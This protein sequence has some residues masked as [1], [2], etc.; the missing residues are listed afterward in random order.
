MRFLTTGSNKDI[1]KSERA[2]RIWSKKGSMSRV[3]CGN[4]RTVI[5]RSM[6]M[7]WRGKRGEVTGV[8]GHV[9]GCSSVHIV[10]GGSLESHAVEVVGEG[11]RVQG[12][13]QGRSV[14]GV[15]GVGVHRRGRWRG[16]RHVALGHGAG[17]HRS[18][19]KH[20]SWVVVKGRDQARTHHRVHV[21]G[22]RPWV[23]WAGEDRHDGRRDTC[24]PPLVVAR[25]GT[26]PIAGVGVGVR[27]RRGRGTALRTA[28]RCGG[29]EGSGHGGVVVQGLHLL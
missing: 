23:L 1:T 2:R 24:L 19:T 25:A 6:S 15:V 4:R 14:A 18:R 21:D 3:S 20:A 10:V 8:R 28:L 29:V 26:G 12:R 17:R 7:T 22:T 27:R 9:S 16:Q 11:E 13:C 5:N